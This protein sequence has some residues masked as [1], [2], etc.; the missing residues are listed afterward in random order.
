MKARLAAKI[1]MYVMPYFASSKM[2]L[3]LTLD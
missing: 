1:T 2:P 3:H